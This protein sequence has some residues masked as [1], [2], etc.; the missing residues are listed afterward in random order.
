MCIREEAQGWLSTLTWLISTSINNK[1]S[2]KLLNRLIRG[3]FLAKK[4]PQKSGSVSVYQCTN[5]PSI[6]TSEW[7]NEWTNEWM[8]EW[9]THCRYASHIRRLKQVNRLNLHFL[10]F[11]F[12]CRKAIWPSLLHVGSFDVHRKSPY[13]KVSQCLASN[14]VY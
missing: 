10:I 12:L 6:D 7:M 13:M 4:I 11:N 2:S 14:Y 8:N 1:Y 9:M 5:M 3:G